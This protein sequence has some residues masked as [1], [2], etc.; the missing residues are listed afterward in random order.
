LTPTQRPHRLGAD[1]HRHRQRL[2]R[3]LCPASYLNRPNGAG[4]GCGTW[5][6]RCNPPLPPPPSRPKPHHTRTHAPAAGPP[7]L[8]VQA[9]ASR[10]AWSARAQPPSAGPGARRAG[11]L[12]RGRAGRKGKLVSS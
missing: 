12:L 10:A 5:G 9:P 8:Q 4:H 1:W 3:P 7:G 6:A 11:G 2:A